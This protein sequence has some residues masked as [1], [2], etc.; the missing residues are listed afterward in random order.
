MPLTIQTEHGFTYIEQGAGRVLMPL[1]GLFGSLSNWEGLLQAFSAAYRVIIP[2]LPIY[3]LPLKETGVMQLVSYLTDFIRYKALDQVTFIGSSL[4]GHVALIYALQHPT[5][6]Q[7]L[8]L[9]GSS[10]LYE[11]TRGGS[12]VRRKDY[13]YVAER[14]RYIFYDP[15]VATPDCIQDIFQMIQDRKKAIRI[16]AMAK[17]AQR[18]NLARELPQI[19]IQTLLIWGLNDPITPP[20]VAHTFHRLM[21]HTTLRFIDKCSHAAMMEHPDKFHE[22]LREHLALAQPVGES[23]PCYQDENLA[24]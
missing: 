22:M 5:Q 9:T 7:Q 13:A 21:P 19:H 17:S 1:H 3:T 11:N 4:G 18:N 8:V 24:S 6:V 16:A 2:M 23:N 12:F 10:G 15:Q 20:L 14:V